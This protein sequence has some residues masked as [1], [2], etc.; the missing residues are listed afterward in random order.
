MRPHLGTCPGEGQQQLTVAEPGGLAAGLQ[1]LGQRG[2]SHSILCSWSRAG[3][4]CW[5]TWG[6]WVSWGKTYRPHSGLYLLSE[7]AVRCPSVQWVGPPR[8]R[9]SSQNSRTSSFCGCSGAPRNFTGATKR[10]RGGLG[11]LPSTSLSSALHGLTMQPAHMP[12]QC[13]PRSSLAPAPHPIP[14]SPHAAF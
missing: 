13:F 1:E 12:H 10:E 14:L 6:Q 11:Q 4:L 8:S 2:P 7:E 5:G 3:A 9:R